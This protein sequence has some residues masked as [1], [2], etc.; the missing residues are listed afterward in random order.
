M[1][2]MNREN[3][4]SDLNDEQ[5]SAVTHKGSP[6]MIVAGAGTGKTTVITRRIAWLM[7]ECGLKI[8]EVL[9]LTFTEKASTEME[10]RV[11]RLLPYGYVQLWI[12]TFHSFCERLLRAHGLEIGLST[13]FKLLDQTASW[14]LVR[15]NLDHFELNIYKPSGN[16]TKFIHELLAHFSRCKDE[17]ISPENYREYVERLVDS[18]MSDVDREEIARLQELVHAYA[19]YQQLL[20]EAAALDFGDLIMYTLQLF[21]RRPAILERYRS[22]FREVLVDEFQ[23]T[24]HAQYELVKLLT[25]KRHALTVVGDDDQSIYRWRGTSL[26][27]IHRFKRDFSECH[28]LCLIRNYRSCQNILDCAYGLI[29]Y[30]NPNRL[31]DR[32]RQ[33]D[34]SF[35]KKLIAVS[36]EAMGFLYTHF[37]ATLDEEVEWVLKKIIK[38]RECDPML[39]LGDCAILVRSNDAAAPFLAKCYEWDIP[40]QY[41]G[42]RGLYLKTPVID[43]LSYVS[44]AVNEHDS[45]SFYRVLTLPHHELSPHGLAALLQHAQKNGVSLMS[46]AR[47][48]DTIVDM[49]KLDHTA[50]SRLI[51]V[52][53]SFHMLGRLRS[54]SESLC[55]IISDSGYLARLLAQDTL[56]SQEYLGYINQLF[57]KAKSFQRENPAGRLHDFVD[58][59]RL[60][61]EAGDAGALSRENDAGSDALKIMTIHSSKGLEFRHVFIVSLIDG[62]F[63]T[64]SRSEGIE[65]PVGLARESGEFVEEGSHLEEERRL[66]YVA[67]TRA[68]EGVYLTGAADYG[69]SRVRKPSLFINE[70]SLIDTGEECG[71]KS[72]LLYVHPPFVAEKISSRNHVLPM[73]I[74]FSQLRAFQICPLQYR[75]SFILKIPTMGRHQFSFGKTMHAVL[76]RYF[77]QVR[78]LSESVTVSYTGKES[79][80]THEDN[81]RLLNE[82][83]IGEWYLSEAHQEEYRTKALAILE[84]ILAETASKRPAICEL[85]KDF[86]LKLGE[87]NDRIVLKGRIDRIDSVEGGVEIIDYKTGTS[88]TEEKIRKDDKEQLLIYQIAAEE[89]LGMRPLKLVYYYVEDGSRIEFAGTKRDKE[90]LKQSIFK[91]VDAM[92]KSDFAAIPGLHCRFCD[93]KSICEYKKL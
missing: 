50:L 90:R 13:D 36:E 39:S 6:L 49:D 18:S 38:L 40:Y 31:E 17:D 43:V 47:K 4:L 59:I 28:E 42:M 77:Q 80:P 34:I 87:G 27:N 15:R 53:D 41:Y 64:V 29:Q 92:K 85:E 66:M 3:L 78:T 45:A 7:I 74:S 24:N 26:A 51:T 84:R 55:R 67:V 65:L 21:R 16:P 83:W 71:A 30:N 54:A 88:K 70:C 56:R 37:C 69:G 46:A 61:H 62:R 81:I 22:Q 44:L 20:L 89:S 79:L 86:T 25:G 93:Y 12:S 5:R 73:A 63:P 48:A 23:D 72:A 76:E 8:D 33:S 91:T 1:Q 14:I 68:K 75:Y 57:S 11:D 60:E 10:E 58:H 9:S 52:L 35:S 32:F 19:T 82:C 2:G